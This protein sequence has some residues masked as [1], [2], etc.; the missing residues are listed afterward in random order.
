M[1]LQVLP[2][3]LALEVRLVGALCADSATGVVNDNYQWRRN[4][5][6]L[7]GL[8]GRLTGK[9]TSWLANWLASCCWSPAIGRAGWLSAAAAASL[10][11]A[12]A[13]NAAS[14][15][16]THRGSFAAAAAASLATAATHQ[17]P[18][19][20][21]FAERRQGECPAIPD[22]ATSLAEQSAA[23]VAASACGAAALPAKAN[24]RF[25]RLMM[26]CHA[27][28]VVVQA[29]ASA[30]EAHE[31]SGVSSTLALPAMPSAFLEVICNCGLPY[32][33]APRVG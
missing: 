24:A 7:G 22:V 16:S 30:C 4:S 5:N 31:D 25:T 33:T 21:A 20:S 17:A 19:A 9:L 12:L 10:A 2:D 3:H 8:T 27:A 18:F 32:T 26:R 29:S 28:V 15:A 23:V 13:A 1:L 6:R 11:A 14:S